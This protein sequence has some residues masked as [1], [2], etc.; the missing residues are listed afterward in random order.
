M[1][2]IPFL[3]VWDDEEPHTTPAELDAFFGPCAVSVS[4]YQNAIQ[5]ILE[6][7]GSRMFPIPV[8]LPVT[9]SPQVLAGVLR[10]GA[11]PILLDIERNT[12]Q[13]SPTLLTE[14][15]GELEDG[16][17]IILPRVNGVPVSTELF[18]ACAGF[19][20]IDDS[21]MIPHPQS[22]VGRAT[23]TVF[24]TS[25]IAGDG[26]VIFHEHADQLAVMKGIRSAPMGLSGALTG[27]NASFVGGQCHT[28]LVDRHYS[29]MRLALS[30][31]NEK[32][33]EYVHYDTIEANRS[34]YPSYVLCKSENSAADIAD[35]RMHGV[36]AKFGV[37]G[38]HNLPEIQERYMD[39][40]EY[41]V[42]D[43]M[44][45]TLVALPLNPEE[46]IPIWTEMKK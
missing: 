10:S 40:P 25:I 42:A 15:L 4:T 43:E 7:M 6:S 29:R 16:A 19:P 3:P 5:V 14:I 30:E 11:Q 46:V 8:I 39:M 26:A 41:P 27:R 2:K 35:L 12:L 38:L 21:R 44:K 13:M 28:A 9:A 24:D 36:D 20:T 31:Y 34:F 1:I 45:K 37:F 18:G 17:V 22:Q 32:L 23:F 33:P